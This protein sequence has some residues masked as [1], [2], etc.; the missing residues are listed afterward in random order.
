MLWEYHGCAGHHD[1][2]LAQSLHISQKTQN[3]QLSTT[4]NHKFIVY[5]NSLRLDYKK[6][7]LELVSFFYIWQYTDT[8]FSSLR[9]SIRL[10]CLDIWKIECMPVCRSAFRVHEVCF[11]SN[12]KKVLLNKTMH[13]RVCIHIWRQIFRYLGR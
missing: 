11:I 9:L 2:F 13:S 1:W 10:K 3:D 5:Q 7:Y 8:F 12:S 6:Y 4:P